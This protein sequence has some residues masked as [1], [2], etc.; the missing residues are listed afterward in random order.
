MYKILQHNSQTKN[1]NNTSN[2]LKTMNSF[3]L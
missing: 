1:A 2:I 3:K